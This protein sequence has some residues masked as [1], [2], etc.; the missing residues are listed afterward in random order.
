M[1][2]KNK[3]GQSQQINMLVL[4]LLENGFVLPLTNYLTNRSGGCA[5]KCARRAAE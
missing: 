2:I 4:T 3:Q 5:R 1:V